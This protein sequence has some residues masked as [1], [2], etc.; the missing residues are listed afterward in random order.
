MAGTVAQYQQG[1]FITPVNGATAD[2]SV[3]LSNDNTL[4]AKYNS[5]DADPTIHLQSSAL[6]SRPAAGTASRVWI[7][8]D[9]KRL[10]LDSGSAWD[11]VDYLNQTAGGTVAGAVTLSASLTAAAAS[12]SGAVTMASTL[13]VTGGATL[14]SSGSAAAYN[15][16]V[17]SGTVT[18]RIT[19]D[20]TN[21]FVAVGSQGAHPVLIKYNATEIARFAST[22]NI[23]SAGGLTVSSGSTAVQALAAT[24]ATMSSTVQAL[25]YVAVGN[26]NPYFQL[27]DGTNTAYVQ[28]VSG[29]LDLFHNGSSRIN[30]SSAGAVLIQ[31]NTTISGAVGGI[32]TLTATTLAGT[33]ST[34]AQPNVTS[35]GTLTGL[36]VAGTAVFNTI[37]VNAD[38]TY[39]IGAAASARPRT[40]YVGTSVVA[41]TFTG[42][43][44]GNVT[45]NVTGSSGSCT[46]NAATATALQT[47]RTINGTSFNGTANITVT[48]AAGTLTGATLAAGV[49]ASSLTSVG[50]LSSLAVTGTATL[51]MATSSTGSS[52]LGAG[53]GTT[54]GSVGTGDVYLVVARSQSTNNYA[55]ALAVGSA[56]IGSVVVTSLGASGLTIGSSGVSITLTNGTAGTLTLDYSL[57]K[58]R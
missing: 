48:A 26:V 7:T 53:S 49:T 22:G 8:T 41:P 54:I 20:G 40:V 56:V 34:A 57:L 1:A 17:L 39:D 4:R 29:G 24:T 35:L 18:C 50:T 43:L 14:G 38:N 11:E 6:A 10:Y 15:A 36:A 23:I 28:I 27:N 45:G 47:A 25:N 58:L 55:Y 9:G 12:F 2:A 32:T 16:D 30:I 52:S 46:G 42:N 5:H 33:L 19:A 31:G 3:V 13:A 44:T 37:Q 21:A 51:G